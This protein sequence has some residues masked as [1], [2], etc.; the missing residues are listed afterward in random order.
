M[1]SGQMGQK[2]PVNGVSKDWELY[3]VDEVNL[4]FNR[5]VGSASISN[6]NDAQRSGFASKAWNIVGIGMFILIFGLVV[7][8]PLFGQQTF[9]PYA[10]FGMLFVLPLFD[11]LN[12]KNQPKVSH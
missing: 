7:V 11:T 5:I 4:E 6:N 1:G 12:F 3:D 9:S 2:Q 10:L 8:L